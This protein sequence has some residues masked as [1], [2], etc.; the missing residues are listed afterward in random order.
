L[1]QQR[2][3]LSP[4][5]VINTSRGPWSTRDASDCRQSIPPG[6]RFAREGCRE[7]RALPVYAPAV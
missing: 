1:M 4:G 6:L 3:W 7:N 2:E 5:D